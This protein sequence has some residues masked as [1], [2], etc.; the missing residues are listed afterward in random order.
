MDR[1]GTEHTA[2]IATFGRLQTK[3]VIKDVA[4]ILGIEFDEVNAFTKLLPSGPGANIHIEDIFNMPEC[5]SFIKKYPK[6]FEYASKLEGSPRHV[7]QHAAGMV[8]TPP[9]HPIW[10]LIPIQQAKKDADGIVGFLTQLEK[11][12]VEE[13]GLQNIMGQ[14]INYRGNCWNVA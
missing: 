4:K 7:G 9:D 2:N 3:A 6:L 14:S 10:S 13:L 8:V 11:G 5:Q 12:P 1:F